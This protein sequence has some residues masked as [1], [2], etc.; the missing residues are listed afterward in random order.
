MDR[1]KIPAGRHDVECV[2]KRSRFIA[3]VNVIDDRAGALRFVSALREQFP[4]ANHHCWAYLSGPPGDLRQ[5]DKS[6]DGEPRGTAGRPILNVLEH[7][8]LGCIVAVVTRYFGGVKLGAGGLVRA[9]GQSVNDALLALPTTT[10]FIT[11]AVQVCLPYAQLASVEHWLAG[12]DIVVRDKTFADEVTLVLDVPADFVERTQ[13]ALQAL[14]QGGITVGALEP[15][16]G[17]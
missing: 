8:G 5:A 15:A 10:R 13:Q 2:I 4:D 6:D 17:S 3:S 7:S 9:Y 16:S 1:Y 11:V 14:G 12:T